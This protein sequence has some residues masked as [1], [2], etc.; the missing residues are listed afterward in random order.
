[1]FTLKYTDQDGNQRLTSGYDIVASKEVTSGIFTGLSWLGPNHDSCSIAYATTVYVLNDA[2]NVVAKYVISSTIK[3]SDHPIGF[4]SGSD[5]W[6]NCDKKTASAA[7]FDPTN[8]Y[9]LQSN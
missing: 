2:G 5:T 6:I 4:R 1:M 7:P 9:S 8:P 3:A